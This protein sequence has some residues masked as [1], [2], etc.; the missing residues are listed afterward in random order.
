MESLER[1]ALKILK[2]EDNAHEIKYPKE[3]IT[4]MGR[5]RLSGEGGVWAEAE[6]SEEMPQGVAGSSPL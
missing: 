2:K 5:L 4:L 6:K 3:D 1:K